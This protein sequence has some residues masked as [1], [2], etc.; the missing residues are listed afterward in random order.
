MK[1]PNVTRRRQPAPSRA[2]RRSL[3]AADHPEA[4][5]GLRFIR[6]AGPGHQKKLAQ[7]LDS[8]LRLNSLRNF[9]RNNRGKV[10]V[11]KTQINKSDMHSFMSHSSR[12]RVTVEEE[13]TINQIFLKFDAGG[14]GFLTRHE[15]K[16]ACLALLGY[17]PAKVRKVD[18]DRASF[19][20]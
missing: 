5:P 8:I 1:V 9:V 14:K 13:N 19:K 4:R 16:C 6:L 2:K 20:I 15:L 12:Q 18:A 7:N 10:S 11:R 17:K 3:K